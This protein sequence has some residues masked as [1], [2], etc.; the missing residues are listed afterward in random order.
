MPGAA[1]IATATSRAWVST[2]ST[3][4]TV[5]AVSRCSSDRAVATSA[6]KAASSRGGPPAAAISSSA[7]ASTQ[8]ATRSG[9]SPSGLNCSASRVRGD[10]VLDDLPGRGAGDQHQ[11]PAGAA[12]GQPARLGLGRDDADADGLPLVHQRRDT[13]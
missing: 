8:S 1:P 12:P 11:Q 7:A 13:R 9:I 4:C 5:S 3:F 10:I 6:A 2:A